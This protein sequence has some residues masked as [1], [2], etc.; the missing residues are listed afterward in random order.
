[1]VGVTLLPRNELALGI[2]KKRKKKW[3][4]SHEVPAGTFIYI[5]IDAHIYIHIFVYIYRVDPGRG[6]VHN[7]KHIYVYI[8][9]KWTKSH[10][11]LRQ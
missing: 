2:E 3:T 1:M 10:E 4:K 6:D 11:V 8:Y 7:Y 5:Y 9:I